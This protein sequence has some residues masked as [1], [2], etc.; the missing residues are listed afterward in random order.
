ML[1]SKAMTRIPIDE[2]Q[3]EDAHAEELAQL[4]YQ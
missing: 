1:M 3:S 2:A 4:D